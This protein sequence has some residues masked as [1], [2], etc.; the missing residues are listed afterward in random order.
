[1]SRKGDDSKTTRRTVLRAVGAA[2]ATGAV[3]GMASPAA[4]ENGA[5]LAQLKQKEAQHMDPTR[6]SWSVAQ[7]AGPTMAALA[8]EGYLDSDSV[9]EL[10]TDT[11]VAAS[12]FG[13][14]TEG[15]MVSA[16]HDDGLTGLIVVETQTDTHR[17]D[18]VV[19]PENDRSY[20][21]VEPLGGGER[22]TVRP[23]RGVT[24]QGPCWYETKCR[25]D[26]CGT[27]L[28]TYWEYECCSQG[29]STNCDP[30]YSTGDCC[31]R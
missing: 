9:D 17:I 2:A 15:A 3:A 28:A 10:P 27:K 5:S 26:E 20:A 4:A 21:S 1:M 30:L 31:E 14:V 25:Y 12:E 29:G 24:T 11:V 19:Q 22:V 8:D 23:D 13:D 6:V 7:H 16:H 18:L